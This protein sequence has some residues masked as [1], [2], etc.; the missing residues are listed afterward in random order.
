MK[1]TNG[2]ARVVNP[3]RAFIMAHLDC[4]P[5]IRSLFPD[6]EPN[7]LVRCPWHEDKNASLSITAKGQA[8]CF[9]CGKTAADPVELASMVLGQ[10]EAEIE[11]DLYGYLVPILSNAQ[12][13]Q[14]RLSLDKAPGEVCDYLVLERHLDM[15]TI[16]RYEI[17][18]DFGTNRI[19]VPIYD[20]F[21]FC[22]NFRRFRWMK[23]QV[24]EEKVYNVKGHGECI[25]F[26]WP[27]LLRERRVILVEGEFDAL[28]GRTFG[29][30]TVTWTA[31]AMNYDP[32]LLSQFEGKAVWLLYDKDLS[33]WNGQEQMR[34]ALDGVA[35]HVEVLEPLHR[36]KGKD[37]TDWSFLVPS[38]V[39]YLKVILEK[40]KFPKRALPTKRFC[41]TC[42][43]EIRQ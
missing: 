15:R 18:Y 10:P 31:G 4:A 42:G 14:N 9:G 3:L 2:L 40:F 30:P 16:K 32:N 11:R 22:R 5:L 25:L 27:D 19:T 6:W 8:R 39:E 37:L 28:V 12:V 20:Q 17:G 21:G 41:P 7:R 23:K 35:Q 13:T 34:R 38:K 43:Q 33:G 29:L 1:Q 24:E 36:T 26:P